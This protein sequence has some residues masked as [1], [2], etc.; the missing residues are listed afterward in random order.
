[1]VDLNQQVTSLVIGDAMVDR[2]YYGTTSRISPEAPIPILDV[3]RQTNLPGGAANVAATLSDLKAIVHFLSV[4]GNDPDGIML[5]NMLANHQIPKDDIITTNDRPTT[6]KQ[7][8][9][10]KNRHLLRVDV[11]QTDNINTEDE[12][13][14]LENFHAIMTKSKPNVVI[15]QDYNKGLLTKNII[16]NIIDTC[17][18]ASV[19]VCVD[20]KKNNFD[21][22]HDVFLFKPNE[23]EFNDF[24]FAGKTASDKNH[25]DE[26]VLKQHVVDFQNKM[27]INNILLTRGDKGMVLFKDYGA[28]IVE[29]EAKKRHVVDVTGAGDTVIS[30][31]AY[32]IALNCDIEKAAAIANIAGGMTCEK[33]GVTTLTLEELITE[34]KKFDITLQ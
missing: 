28:T 14:V 29:I 9:I 24:M 6:V 2:Y 30:V 15:L 31:M 27:H 18:A 10:S 13:R 26:A 8:F 32:L 34:L 7:R 19:K 16:R 3:V 11:E 23:K 17:N 21:T 20:P 25:D 5:T 33:V 4:V 12:K 22:Y 1:M